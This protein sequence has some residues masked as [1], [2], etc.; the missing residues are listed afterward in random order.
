MNQSTALPQWGTA[1]DESLFEPL[2]TA[3]E[4]AAH[5]RIHTKTLQK[6]ARAGIVP[7][8]RMGKY[9][10]FRLSALDLWVCGHENQSSQPSRVK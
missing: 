9:W 4:A 8:A 3:E 7:C 1:K 2:L 10:R 5:L 6:F